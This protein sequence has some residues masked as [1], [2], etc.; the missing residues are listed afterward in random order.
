MTT[1]TT[2]RNRRN[3]EG[4]VRQRTDGRWEIRWRDVRGVRRSAYAPDEAAGRAKL[5][6]VTADRDRGAPVIDRRWTVGRWVDHWYAGKR[7]SLRPRS[8]VTYRDWIRH[9]QRTA[10]ADRRLVELM[11]EHVAAMLRELTRGGMSPAQLRNVHGVLVSAL[12]A[13]VVAETAARNVARLVKR[14]TVERTRFDPPAGADLDLIRAAIADD[15]YQAAYLLALDCG[16][17]IG[18]VLAL[19][20]SD[21]EPGGR[22]VVRVA[23]T[24]GL[25]GRL[26]PPKSRHGSRVI[27]AGDHV[28]DALR[29]H[30]AALYGAGRVAPHPTAWVFPS[31]ELAGAPLTP[32]S[33]RVRWGHVCDRAGVKRYRFHDLR[34][35]AAT[36]LIESGNPLLIVSRYLGHGS[37]G[38]T[39]DTYGHVRLDDSMRLNG[40]RLTPTSDPH[41]DGRARSR[42]DGSAR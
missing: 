34:H 7:E 38:I 3:G 18:E 41:A 42:A 11:P 23:H 5:R 21:I 37:I 12:D 22:P 15:P 28:F 40:P 32:R 29:R 1:N 19:T 25:D 16:L 10:I 13:A 26:A 6:E 27:P 33:L 31:P 36:S 9:L 2:T 39:A 35:A 4:S 24:L 8:V 17:R 14:P 20:W 30:R